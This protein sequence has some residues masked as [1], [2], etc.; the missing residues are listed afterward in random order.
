M[1]G[2]ASVQ[3]VPLVWAGFEQMPVPG[4]QVPATWHWSLAVHV[5]PMHLLPPLELEDELDA[6]VALE[7]LDALEL[8]PPPEPD[9]EADTDVA[10]LLAA[11][12][13][14]LP[15]AATK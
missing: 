13:P 2:S 1:Q 10:P 15:P 7:A 9:A 11:A 8:D 5:T 3:D 12:P 14:P 4:S 6:V